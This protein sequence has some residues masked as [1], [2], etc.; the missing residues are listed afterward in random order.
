MAQ[1]LKN[2][3]KNEVMIPVNKDCSICSDTYTAQIRKRTI[4]KYCKK[5]TCSKCIEQYLLTRTEDAHCIHC[6]VHYNDK[7]LQEICTKTYLKDRYF[8]HRQE[9]L[10]N[11]ERANLPGLQDEAHRQKQNRDNAEMSTKIRKEIDELLTTR[12]IIREE[13]IR[14]TMS[15]DVKD[16]EKKRESLQKEMESYLEMIRI[17]KQELTDIRFR[18]I[19][20]NEV[21][22]EKKEEERKKFIRRCMRAGCNGFLSTA[23]KCGMC[24]WYSCSKCFAA[25]GQAHDVAHECIKEDLETADLIRKDSKPCPNCGE[26]I[27]K[28]SGCFA[29]NTPILLWNGTLKMSQN[30]AVGDEL[31]G[32]DG[33]KRTVLSLVA[34]NDIMYEVV[35]NNGMT[36]VVNSKH[37]LLL[38]H[39]GGNHINWVDSDKKWELNWFEQ[40]KLQYKSKIMRATDETKEQVLQQMEEFKASLKLPDAIEI[41]VEDYMGLTASAKKN[42]VGF[43]CQ[44]LNPNKDMLRTSISVKAIGEGEYYGWSVDVNK[45][46]L[47]SDTTCVRNCDQM[48]CI[49]CQTPF[50]WNTGKIVTSGAIHNPHYY[51]MMKRKGALPRNPGDVPCG[52]FPTRYQLVQHPRNISSDIGDYY[53]EFHRLCEEVQDASRRQF[54]THIDNGTTHAINVRYLLGDFTDAK[55]GQQLAINEK[56]KKRDAE[57]QEVFAAFLMVAVNIINTVQNYRT[58]EYESFRKLPIVMAERILMDLHVEIWELITIMNNAFKDISIAYAYTTPFIDVSACNPHKGITI[59]RLIGKNYKNEK[60]KKRVIKSDSE[61]DSESD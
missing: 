12:N 38:Q 10:I 7:D 57:V 54:R 17:K 33:Q 48:F 43:K 46:F 6:R 59:Y 16:D 51:E 36:Y 58:D 27:S 25:K 60:G 11:R 8:K 56:K 55:W 45:R 42:L 41:M 40:D 1:E 29:P 37:K 49:T 18:V 14:V 24:E 34:G 23:W 31:I 52:G 35:Q 30:I 44:Y 3:V 39:S 47:L 22:E 20:P 53:F 5:D 28:V 9:I 19:L 13:F 32:D 21:V 4:C 15:D 61:S 2:E 26:F 50:S